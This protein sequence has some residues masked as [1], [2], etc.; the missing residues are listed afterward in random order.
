M[1]N[2]ISQSSWSLTILTKTGVSAEITTN[3]SSGHFC[4]DIPGGEADE[5]LMEVESKLYG[6]SSSTD[7]LLLLHRTFFSE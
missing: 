1:T 3:R 7:F 2:A 6:Y 5:T 4:V